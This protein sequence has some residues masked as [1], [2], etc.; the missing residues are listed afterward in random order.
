MANWYGIRR[1]SR[2]KYKELDT[3]DSL[4]CKIL[5][6]YLH[7]EAIRTVTRAPA[8]GFQQYSGTYNELLAIPSVMSDLLIAVPS[9]LRK[10]YV[11]AVAFLCVLGTLEMESP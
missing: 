6:P 8:A 4:P 3:I 1:T 2:R 5:L 10:R 9:S 11:G 7:I